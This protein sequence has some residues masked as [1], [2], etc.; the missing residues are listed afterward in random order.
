MPY[1]SLLFC[2]FISFQNLAQFLS[3]DGSWALPMTE[4]VELSAGFGDLRP[5]HFH[6]GIDIRTRGKINL[7]IY[8]CQDGF[9]SRIRVSSV[10]YGWVLYVQH[11]NGFTT[12][13]A[14]C[15]RF[16][17]PIQQI[18]LDSAQARQNNEIDLI[19][20]EYILPVK[21][22]EQIA[23]SGN[24]GG[25]TG[26]HLH[27]ELRDTKTEHALNPFL[28]GFKVSDQATP[29]LKGIRVYAIDSLGYIV[30]NKALNVS[31][32]A[33]NHRVALPAG[34]VSEG[35]K[36]GV[37]LEIDDYFSKAGRTY[38]VFSSEITAEHQAPCAIE[39]DEIDFEHSRYINDHHDAVYAK[40]SQR[41]FQKAFK[42]VHNPLTIYPYP[43]TGSFTIL[44]KDSL[45]LGIM[46]RDVKGNESQHTLTVLNTNESVRGTSFYNSVSHWLPNEKYKYEQGAWR[47]EIDSFTFY[48]PVLKKLNLSAKT[49]GSAQT[50]IQKPIVIS[51]RFTT[52]NNPEKYCIM[53]NGSPLSGSLKNGIL[54][55]TTKS[56]G[57]YGLKQ[58]LVAPVV[59]E[60]PKNTMDS[61]SN[62]R[63]AWPVQDDF[64]GISYYACFQNG[65]WVPAY[66]D[67]KNKFISTQFHV[68]FQ[69]GELLEIVV[70]D[71]VGNQTKKE[72]KV[73]VKPKATP[74]NPALE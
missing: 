18:Y 4:P 63:W 37:A 67:A 13:Y 54:S 33:V 73:P 44:S 22:G 53:M 8:A 41:K 66:Y 35:Q 57:V 65:K 45:Q 21:K 70:R 11:P 68:P 55:A 19:L 32:T 60:N 39:F 30:P 1:L 28:H 5:N 71:A 14:H 15:T 20:P 25:S 24:S 40:A 42:N 64:S 9:V 3:T 38:G 51:Y 47:I 72:W 7:P 34:F 2:L 69:E 58:D 74:Q 27:F 43:G 50:Y 52:E 16:S 23:F 61:T 59:K 6:M 10:G 17:D 48:E 12:V 46:L 36:I 49:I 26:P 56:M 29:V 62:G 31:L